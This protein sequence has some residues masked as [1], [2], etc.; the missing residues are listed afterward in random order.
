MY[1]GSKNGFIYEMISFLFY[2]CKLVLVWTKFGIMCAKYKKNYI[3]S[4]D[5]DINKKQYYIL[6][7]L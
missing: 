7:V 3:W 4:T 2:Y 5:S 1:R 6:S